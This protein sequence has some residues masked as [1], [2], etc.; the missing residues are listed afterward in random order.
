MAAALIASWYGPRRSARYVTL[1]QRYVGPFELPV[2][3]EL[4]AHRFPRCSI[5][6]HGAELAEGVDRLAREPHDDVPRLET[7][8]PRWRVL[9]DHLCHQHSPWLRQT[10]ALR[11]RGC[12][13][14]HRNAQPAARDASVLDQVVVNPPCKIRGDGKKNR[15]LCF[16]RFRKRCWS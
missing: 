7:R 3:V 1:T 2:A 9:T 5:R 12:E 10:E 15:C 13:L 16:H 14:L 11:Q 6:H 8:L 4:D